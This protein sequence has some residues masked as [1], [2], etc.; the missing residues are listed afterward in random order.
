M[1][2]CLP[3]IVNTLATDVWVSIDLGTGF[4]LNIPVVP[5][6]LCF[7]LV[8]VPIRT[9][10]YDYSSGSEATLTNVGK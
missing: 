9:I 8:K 1:R 7:I 2:T 5:D 3:C 6:L 4:T 10:I